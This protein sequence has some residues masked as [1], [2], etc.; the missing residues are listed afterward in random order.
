M[1]P[2]GKLK[3]AS[4]SEKTHHSNH[5]HSAGKPRTETMH[6]RGIIKKKKNHHLPHKRNKKN[7]KPHKNPP[8]EFISEK[9]GL[10]LKGRG[11][12]PGRGKNS[13]VRRKRS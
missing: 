11:K 13:N 8:R 2:M 1:S 3:G 9:R 10:I 7:T 12:D 6:G 4:R 5:S